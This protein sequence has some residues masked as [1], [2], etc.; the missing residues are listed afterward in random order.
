MGKVVVI[1]KSKYESSKKY[2]GWIAIKLDADLYEVGDI[3]NKDLNE[4]D[5]IIYGAGMY[6]GKINGINFI[7]KNF[8]RIKGKKIIV[9]SVGIESVNEVS[10]EKIIRN[11]FSEDL[12]NYIKFF[13][14][15]G[16]IF[17]N[18]L[19]FKDKILMKGLSA[20]ID[21]KNK[22]DKT[23]DDKLIMKS[24]K[25]KIDLCDKNSINELIEYVCC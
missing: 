17:Y 25:S 20:Y 23:E 10:K 11:N 12:R 13:S 14:F 18:D 5:T 21:K 4:Y 16:A 1:Y 7:I 15:R 24:F 9:F 2:A 8:E 22:L 3:R 19:S 6:R